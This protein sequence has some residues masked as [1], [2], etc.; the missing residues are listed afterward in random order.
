MQTALFAAAVT[1]YVLYDLDIS[2]LVFF[3][4][5][6]KDDQQKCIPQLYHSKRTEKAVF[7]VSCNTHKTFLKTEV[8]HQ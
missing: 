1:L 8:L 2:D 7:P 3:P 5:P 6:R 4:N